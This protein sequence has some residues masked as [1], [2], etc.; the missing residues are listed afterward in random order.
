M[1]H[2]Q[3]HDPQM[4]KKIWSKKEY[5]RMLKGL[6]ATGQFPE[7]KLTELDEGEI[8]FAVTTIDNKVVIEF[9][10][11]VHWMGMSGEQAV[12]LGRLLIKRGRKILV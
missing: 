6:G 11:P 10:K 8:K 1:H 4:F 5:Q 2:S 9:G 7:G 12:D 3:E